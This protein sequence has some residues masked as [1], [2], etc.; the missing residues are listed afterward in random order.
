M[1]RIDPVTGVI[2]ETLPALHPS[3]EDR[4]GELKAD[5]AKHGHR[6]KNYRMSAY[7]GC[8]GVQAGGIWFNNLDFLDKSWVPQK[9]TICWNDMNLFG[10][11]VIYTNG[12]EILNG[13]EGSQFKTRSWNFG[14][15]EFTTSI[16]IG[17]HDDTAD[18][19]S[20]AYVDELAIASN[21][22]VST[23]AAPSPRPN[24][25]WKTHSMSPGAGWDIRG[26]YGSYHPTAGLQQLGV[27]WGNEKPGDLSLE[28]G[29]SLYQESAGAISV[30]K[31]RD[32][33]LKHS[34]KGA[35]FRLSIFAGDS[36]SI[37]DDTSEIFNS[38]DSIDKTWKIQTLTAYFDA[39]TTSIL[40]GLQVDYTNGKQLKHGKC[41]G[42]ETEQWSA[43]GARV[44]EVSIL[45]TGQQPA[46]CM[47]FTLSVVKNNQLDL[48][49]INKKSTDTVSVLSS[50]PQRSSSEQWS[51]VGFVGTSGKAGIERL[52]VVWGKE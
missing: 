43:A 42:A 5:V 34:T 38:L 33:T 21:K 27:I 37:L 29:F 3:P 16:K 36:S 17:S 40:T 46:K 2:T 26:F 39:A 31:L 30:G 44:K 52:A 49:K 23:Y 35:T 20:P 10:I 22:D 48:A 6:S 47:G 51:I 15:D 28:P 14:K 41:E 1:Q 4:C 45:A 32:A 18:I 25:N 13:V 7:T 8:W 24:K 19:T 9:M 50:T 12:K 11:K